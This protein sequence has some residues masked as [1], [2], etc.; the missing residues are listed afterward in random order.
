MATLEEARRAKA[1]IRRALRVRHQRAA[2]GLGLTRAGYCVEVE[3]C[4]PD[5]LLAP[6]WNGVP[7]RTRPLGL[8]AI[9]A[10]RWTGRPELFRSLDTDRDGMVSRVELEDGLG[11]KA[12]GLLDGDVG[13]I[14]RR[15]WTGRPEIFHLLDLDGDGRVTTAELVGALGRRAARFLAHDH[16]VTG[17]ELP[18]GAEVVWV[19]QGRWVTFQSREDKAAYMAR[20]AEH[21]AHDP[22]VLRWAQRFMALPIDERPLAILRFD[23]HAIRYERDPATWDEDGTRHGIE[24]LDSAATGLQRGYGDCDLKARLYVALCL[25]CGVPGKIDPVFRGETGFP[26]VRAKVWARRE[27][28]EVGAP[29]EWLIADPTMV[30]QERL[31]E[32]PEHPRTS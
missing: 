3:P 9:P 31:G 24:L 15:A 20:A 27:D 32:L 8:D 12:C 16:P 22:M 17:P 18:P 1:E 13:A 6:W 26:H 21:D 4:E 29:K 23:Q 10:Q 28:A 5:M 11:A 30:N 14:D 2:L 7:V 25:A 19:G